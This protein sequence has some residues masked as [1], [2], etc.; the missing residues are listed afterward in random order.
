MES[1]KPFNAGPTL[2]GCALV[3]VALAVSACNDDSNPKQEALN[4]NRAKWE[5]SGVAAYM[6]EQRVACAC[7]FEEPIVTMVENGVVTSA[8]FTPS[9]VN[10]DAERLASVRT[11]D[12]FF[13]VV[14]L[15]INDDAFQLDVSYDNTYGFPTRIAIDF[16]SDV[17]DDEITYTISGFQ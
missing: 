8:F 6:F 15:A 4:E 13:D 5:A 12:G 14:Q 11:L 17:I 9:G 2:R 3:L 7:P 10:L 16:A 1:R